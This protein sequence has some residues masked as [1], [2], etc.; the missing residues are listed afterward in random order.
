MANESRVTKTYTE[1]ALFDDVDLARVT[2]SY[3]ETANYDPQNK[4]RVPKSY[5]EVLLWT[6][7]IGQDLGTPARSALLGC[8]TYELHAIERGGGSVVAVLPYTQLAWG[9]ILDEMSEATVVVPTVGG[10]D[11]EG[12]RALRDVN[13]WEHELRVLRDGR[14]VWV[15]PVVGSGPAE[16]GEATY[17][18]LHLFARDLWAWF[19]RRILRA[20]RTFSNSDLADIFAAY[21]NLALAEDNGMGINVVTQ[22]TGI[23]GTRSISAADPTRAADELRELARDGVDFTFLNRQLLVGNVE[24]P[25]DPV[26]ILGDSH[27]AEVLI[28]GAGLS[29]ATRVYVRGGVDFEAAGFDRTA[30]LGVAGGVDARLGLLEILEDEPAILDAASAR[31][32]AE[33]RLDL[34]RQPPRLVE[35]RLLPEAPVDLARLAPGAR[36]D[37]RLTVGCQRVDEV[38]RLHEL[39][40]EATAE[41]TEAVRVRL[42]PLGSLDG[43]L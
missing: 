18:T 15:G 38:M 9:R 20:D 25:T 5:V 43:G 7:P 16:E 19:E 35:A 32:A 6:D 37:V 3:T 22:D 1:A 34:L 27:V 23:L 11:C 39:R 8:G 14:E 31:V 12:C 4:T 10:Y 24:I 41:E 40:V 30:P 21:A 2:K 17:E 42:Q 13:E 28:L 26:A 29:T 36:V 33:T